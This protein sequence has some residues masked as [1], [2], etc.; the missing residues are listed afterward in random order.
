LGAL[1][2]PLERTG[3][4]DGH[5]QQQVASQDLPQTSSFSFNHRPSHV[6]IPGH[7]VSSHQWYWTPLSVEDQVQNVTG[8]LPSS[9]T[10]ASPLSNALQR[11]G[12]NQ[13]FGHTAVALEG[14]RAGNIGYQHAMSLRTGIGPSQGRSQLNTTMRASTSSPWPSTRALEFRMVRIVHSTQATSTRTA[15]EVIGDTSAISDDSLSTRRP[16]NETVIC[17]CFLRHSQKEKYPW[18]GQKVLEAATV[19]CWVS[20]A[21]HRPGS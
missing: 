2:Y 10:V 20:R 14:P 1:D 8:G 11:E 18:A 3:H 9:L 7:P 21:Q 19:E 17:I 15:I 4:G 16:Y 5:F 6:P 13:E 12:F